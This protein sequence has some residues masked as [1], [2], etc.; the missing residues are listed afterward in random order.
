M[1]V[2]LSSSAAARG[3]LAGIALLLAAYLTYFSVRTARATYYTEEQT[4]NGYERAT[5]I[6]PE[7]ARNWYLLGQYLQYSLED[8]NPE[9]AISSYRRA[10]EIDPHGT[11]TWLDLA[12]MYESEGND[13]AARSAFLNAKESYPLSAEVSWRYGNFLLR[14]GQL[15][16]AFDEI[17]RSVEADPSRAAEAFS[18]AARVEPDAEVILNRV[19][20]VNQNVYLAVIQDLTV[21]Q[22]VENALK[23]WRRL[24]AM[25]P[26]IALQDAFML[27]MTLRQTGRAQEAHEVW[28]QAAEFAGLEQ[29]EGPKNSAVWDGGFESDV[30]NQTYA[31]TYAWRFSNNSHG[32]QIGFDPQEK[33]SGKRSLRVSFG[34]NSDI[35]FRDVCQTV[36]M[37]GGTSYELSGWMQSKE[38]TTDRG[39]RLEL[40]PGSPGSTA[41][42]TAEIHGTQSWTR[43]EA[44]WEGA[45]DSQETEVCLRREAS[46]QED[47]KIRGTVW[48]DD[49]A[50][51]PTR[52]NSPK[53]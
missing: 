4:L 31:Q 39:V 47:N 37:E 43:F 21:E 3:A 18:R 11:S 52:K 2:S 50:L 1:M 29:L 16:P 20:P 41:V 51:T 23:V 30:T 44:V 28:E 14:Q 45:K 49:V 7:N 19:L 12:A 5:Q 46:D 48:L 33:H 26:K 22:Q 25:R 32:V 35:D 38:L 9:R 6:E 40:R 34:G 36:P 17:K 42:N 13:A 8:Q 10:V 27:V 24:A 53:K 15:D